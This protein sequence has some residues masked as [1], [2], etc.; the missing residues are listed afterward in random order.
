MP[1]GLASR[2]HLLRRVLEIADARPDRG[3]PRLGHHQRLAEAAVEALGGVAHQ[4]DVLALVLPHRH[5]VRAVGEHV[6]G[7]QDGVEEQAGRDELALSDRLVAELVHALELAERDDRGEQPRQLAVLLHVAL[8]EQDAAVRVEARGDQQRG[9]VERALAQ[10][11]GVVV[12]RQRMEVDDA[13]DR[14]VTAVLAGDVLRDAADVVAEVLGARRLD[15]RE[16]PHERAKIAAPPRGTSAGR[17]SGD[18]KR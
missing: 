12:D 18:C 7:H 13:V 3:D 11:G 6:G 2:R 14:R 8:A 17:G 4:L 5:L 10:V 9:E 16:D 1:C 15:A